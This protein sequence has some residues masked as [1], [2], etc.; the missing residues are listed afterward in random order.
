[1]YV[2]GSAQLYAECCQ[3]EA[4]RVCVHASTWG[5]GGVMPEG[6]PPSQAYAGSGAANEAS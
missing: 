4:G 3:A 1:M 6:S 2:A 5:A